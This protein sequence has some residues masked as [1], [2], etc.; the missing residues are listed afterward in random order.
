MRVK[1]KWLILLV[2]VLIVAVVLAFCFRDALMVRL[3][4]RLV[5]SKAVGETFVQLEERYARSPVHLLRAA[6]DPDGCQKVSMKLDTGTQFMGIAHY[7]LELQTQL[8]PNRVQGTGTVSTGAGM[9][10]LSLYMDERFFAVFSGSLTEGIYYGITY[11]TFPQDI[12]SYQLLSFLAGEDVITGWEA[13]I[14]EFSEFM[15]HRYTLPELSADDVRT[16]LMGAL[17]LEPEVRAGKE[18]NCYTVTFREDGDEIAEAAQSYLAQ[19]PD[20]LASLICAMEKTDDSE[21]M[22]VFYLNDRQ[23]TQV[24]AGIIMD[25]ASYRISAAFQENN[26][27]DLELFSYDGENLERTEMTVSTQSDSETYQEKLAVIRTVNGIQTQTTADYS[28]DLSSGDMVMD[29]VLDGEKYP[30][31]LNLTGEGESFALT[32]QEFGVILSAISG[33][34]NPRPAICTITVSPGEPITG[35]PEYRNLSDWS[36]EDFTLLITRLGNLVGIK[37]P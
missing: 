26:T 28:W 8:S 35:V 12:R 34:E 17:S 14:A 37:L 25:S 23:L 20:S 15:G 5:L 13:S 9:M 4:P 30:L 10:D 29:L 31:R 16:A 21:V 32:S 36:V 1:R 11:D 3:F 27:I 33:R 22:V 7:D 6:L 24:D 19:A 18:K 2:I